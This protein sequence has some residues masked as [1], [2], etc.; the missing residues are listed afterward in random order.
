MIKPYWFD[1]GRQLSLDETFALWLNAYEYHQDSDKREYFV[2]TGIINR[3]FEL[4][5]YL[6]MHLV[7]KMR[8]IME[9]FALLVQ[10]FCEDVVP[11]VL[12]GR[13]ILYN[14]QKLYEPTST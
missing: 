4:R 14:G 12:R 3:E 7:E 11:S 10:V 5:H 2:R 9:I 1:N 13:E 6:N 8:A